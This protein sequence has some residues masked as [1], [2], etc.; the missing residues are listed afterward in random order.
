MLNSIW[1]FFPTSNINNI[2]IIIPE[3]EV[4]NMRSA[5][6]GYGLDNVRNWVKHIWMTFQKS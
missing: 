6:S 4:F 5:Y 3:N 1:M 2:N